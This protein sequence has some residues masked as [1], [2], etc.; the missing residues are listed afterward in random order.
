[1][2][3]AAVAR[4]V[5]WSWPVEE[6]IRIGMPAPDRRWTAEDYRVC[7]DVLYALDRTNR[8]AL[9]RMDS[10]RSGPIF[11]RL[12]SSTNTLPLTDRSLPA[13]ERVRFFTHLCNEYTGFLEVYNP[14]VEPALHRENIELN[15]T[16]LRMLRSVV[17]LNER[18]LPPGRGETNVTFFGVSEFSRTA[19]EWIRGSGLDKSRVPPGGPGVVIGAHTARCVN[20]VLPWL[21]DAARLPENERVTGAR[22]LREDVPALWKLIPPATQE[23]L[24][25]E[26]DTVLQ[27]TTHEK[28]REEL[29]SLRARLPCP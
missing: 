16:Y 21:A 19:V 1:V 29:G 23:G 22:Y 12:I 11:A 20:Q 14:T 4:P 15:H 9:P 3:L 6:Y 8:A 27:R 5:D 2:P 24:V 18:T 7:R 25:N 10:R 26:L 28:V 17:E 13:R